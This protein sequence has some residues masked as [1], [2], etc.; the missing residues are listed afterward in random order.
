MIAQYTAK[1]TALEISISWFYL[2]LFLG[3]S[4]MLIFHLHLMIRT[5]RFPNDLETK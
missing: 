3:S 2:G 1:T 5:L 4:G